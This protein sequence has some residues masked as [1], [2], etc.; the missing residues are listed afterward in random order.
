MRTRWRH[1]AVGDVSKC[2]HRSVAK[3]AQD[4]GEAGPRRGLGAPSRTPASRAP[5]VQSRGGDG[6]LPSS[7]CAPDLVALSGWGDARSA[8]RGRLPGLPDSSVS[9]VRL[10]VLPPSYPG[11]GQDEFHAVQCRHRAFRRIRAVGHVARPRDR[12]VQRTSC[13]ALHLTSSTRNAGARRWGTGR[14]VSRAK[15]PRDCRGW[16]LVAV[17]ALTCEN[18]QSAVGS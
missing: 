6:P 2:R 15:A 14:P 18:T 7:D 5:T 17:V 12:H 4:K 16:S 10:R 13:V 9:R 8:F 11:G 3:A 1:S